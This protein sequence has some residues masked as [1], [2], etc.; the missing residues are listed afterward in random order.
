MLAARES[1]N[2]V[3]TRLIPGCAR[4]K[5]EVMEEQPHFLEGQVLVA[6]PGMGDPRFA[7]SVVFICSHSAEGAMGLIINKPAQELDF[8]DL[9]NQLQIPVESEHASPPVYFGG[10]VE[11]G[12]GFVLHTADYSCEG[13]TL[14]VEGG[15][16]MTATLDILRD[17]ARGKGP[18]GA[19]LALGYAG[20][21]PGQLET[22]FQANGWLACDADEA[23]LFGTAP[24]ARWAAA[25]ERIGIDPRLLSSEGGNA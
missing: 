18:R 8:S 4:P 3:R 5:L 16:G 12:R 20:W 21:A 6:M 2:S 11:H 14:E 22:E 17:M 9:L 23:L 19:L 7:R 13:A 1:N 15:F 24:E 25:L 10:P